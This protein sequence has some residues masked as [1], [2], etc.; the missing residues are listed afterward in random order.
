MV[1][2]SGCSPNPGFGGKKGKSRC[3]CSAL[4]AMDVFGPNYFQFPVCQN[5]KHY[6]HWQLRIS[7]FKVIICDIAGLMS[8][9]YFL[10]ELCPKDLKPVCSLEY[11]ICFSVE[12][13]CRLFPTR[14]NWKIMSVKSFVFN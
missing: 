8:L 6:I 9:I 3:G 10:C 7:I 13:L 11:T 14:K 12:S 1:V 4:W 2:I 5:I